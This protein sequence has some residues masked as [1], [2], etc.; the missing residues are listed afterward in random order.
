MK[1][2]RNRRR[3]TRVKVS[4]VPKLAKDALPCF[5]AL[6]TYP[7]TL[8]QGGPRLGGNPAHTGLGAFCR[9]PAGTKIGD[10][11]TRPNPAFVLAGRMTQD[12]PRPAVSILPPSPWGRTPKADLTDRC[13]EPNPDTE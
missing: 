12:I 13:L 6:V 5:V 1:S 11:A 8:K 2:V 10:P 9:H 3:T 4:N 7:R